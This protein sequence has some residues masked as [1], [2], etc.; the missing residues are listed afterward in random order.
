MIRELMRVNMFRVTASRFVVLGFLSPWFEYLGPLWFRRRLVKVLPIP[1]LR[2]LVSLLDRLWAKSTQIVKDKKNGLECGNISDEHVRQG[3]DL[4][5]V[6]RKLP[7]SHC[8]VSRPLKLASIVQANMAASSDSRLPDH[9]L[10]AQI[11]Y[12]VTVLM[13]DI[14]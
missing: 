1:G 13:N 14:S 12:E 8:F 4:L 10:I 3:K 2:A 9:E 5:S 6:L 11:G 7:S